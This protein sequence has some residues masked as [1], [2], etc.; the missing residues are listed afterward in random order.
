MHAYSGIGNP[1]EE[2]GTQSD[3]AIYASFA[4]RNDTRGVAILT[5]G[6]LVVGNPVVFLVCRGVSRLFPRHLL[7]GD[8]GEE[9]SRGGKQ[10][11]EEAGIGM[12]TI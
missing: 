6:V 5:V 8:G 2:D 10:N 7:E 11:D 4:W 9:M 12:A 3:D 1:Y